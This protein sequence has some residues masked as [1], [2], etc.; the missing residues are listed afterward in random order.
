MKISGA[1]KWAVV[2]AWGMGLSVGQAA[3]SPLS[4]EFALLGNLKG[5]QQNPHVAL[6]RT[7]GFV[8]WQTTT[9]SDSTER[10]MVQRLS[11]DMKGLGVAAR[12]SH[13]RD[14]WNELNPRV[15][16]LANGG[17]A[18]V[19]VGGERSSTDVY[20]RF[21]DANGN[22]LGVPTLVNTR[23]KSIQSSQG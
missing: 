23:L 10:V 21:L 1:I 13:S 2:L 9:E 5:H 12:V 19:W 16:M 6:G 20:I 3:L 4:G 11:S 17:A 7:G 8:V 14:R 18:V 22:Y 15:A